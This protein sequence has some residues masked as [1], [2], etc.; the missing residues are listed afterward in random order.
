MQTPGHFCTETY[1]AGRR[2]G[3]GCFLSNPHAAPGRQHRNWQAHTRQGNCPDVSACGQQTSVREQLCCHTLHS[4]LLQRQ[5]RHV[6]RHQVAAVVERHEVWPERV[7]VAAPAHSS[8]RQLHMA[9]ILRGS[10]WLWPHREQEPRRE[11]GHALLV[12]QRTDGPQLPCQVQTPCT[13]Q[14]QLQPP[15]PARCQ[16]ARGAALCPSTRQ[17]RRP[18]VQAH[19]RSEQRRARSKRGP[20]HPTC[21]ARPPPGP[22][23]AAPVARPHT[24]PVSA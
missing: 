19:G 21:T 3:Q 1:S 18:G 12:G 4:C 14:G 7:C 11:R 17:P 2:V 10:T 15:L 20:A 8:Q 9:A 24:L 22:P 5:R 13:P 6:Q 23:A 16:A